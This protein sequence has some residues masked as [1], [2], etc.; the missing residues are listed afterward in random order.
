MS[1]GLSIAVELEE[2][3]W[4]WNRA[5]SRAGIELGLELG[6][7]Y[8]IQDSPEIASLACRFSQI[9]CRQEGKACSCSYKGILKLLGRGPLSRFCRAECSDEYWQLKMFT[10]LLPKRGC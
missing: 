8:M 4:S 9:T 6:V 3:G 5:E 2:A 7:R 10:Q 1:V